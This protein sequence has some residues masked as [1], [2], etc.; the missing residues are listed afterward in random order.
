MK[1]AKTCFVTFDLFDI[2]IL[3]KSYKNKH[4]VH[5]NMV[6]GSSMIGFPLVITDSE[7]GM[8]EN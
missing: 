6:D 7:Q 3:I 8:V 1:R 2:W 5:R 4:A